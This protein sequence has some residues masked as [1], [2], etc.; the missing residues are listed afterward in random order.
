[1]SMSSNDTMRRAKLRLRRYAC[2]ALAGASILVSA[3]GA[4][5]T[6]QAQ[7]HDDLLNRA[8]LSQLSGDW[9]GDKSEQ[10]V[11]RL[12]NVEDWGSY[13]DDESDLLDRFDTDNFDTKNAS[14]SDEE[15]PESEESSSDERKK[16]QDPGAA[17]QPFRVVPGHYWWQPLL[18]RQQ[19]S[20]HNR[21]Q[22]D[23]NSLLVG[24]LANSARIQVIGEDPLISETEI[25]TADAAFDWYSFLEARWDDLDEPVGSTLT[26]GGPSRFRD[27][28][29]NVTGGVR[30]RN[31]LGGELEISQRLGHQNSNSVFFVPNNQGTSRLTFS[32]TQPLLRGA[33]RV[34]NTSMTVLAKLNTNIASDDFHR[35]L[36][37]HLLDVTQAY[38][39]LYFERGKLLQQ[40]K[41]LEN[42]VAILSEL[43]SRKT[44]DALQSQVVRA[45]AAVENRRAQ[46]VRARL[47]IRIAE[48]R[49]RALINDP[50]LGDTD[51]EL[52]PIEDLSESPFHVELRNAISQAMANRPEVN[53]AMTQIKAASVRMNL[54]KN[55]TLPLL[56]V[57]LDSYLAGLEGN[58]RV[59]GAFNDQFTEGVPSYGVGLQ[60]E[61]PIWNRAAQSRLQK[62]RLEL[63]RM[64]HQFRQTMETL[65]LEVEVSVH[66]LNAAFESL[67]AKRRA[68]E[69][70]HEEVSYLKD[71]WELLP[72]DNGSASLLLEDL[73]DAQDRLTDSEESLLQS[74]LEYSLAQV[75][76]KKSI[77]ALLSHNNIQMTRSCDCNLPRQSAVQVAP[78]AA[79]NGEVMSFGPTQFG[80]T[81]VVPNSVGPMM[82]T[83]PYRVDSPSVESPGFQTPSIEP[84]NSSS[85]GFQ[86]PAKEIGEPRGLDSA[87]DSP[88]SNPVP[89]ESPSGSARFTNPPAANGSSD[90]SKPEPNRFEEPMPLASK[91]RFGQPAKSDRHKSQ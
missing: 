49:L 82:E 35:Q 56:N 15:D 34:Y 58:S 39:N 85:E 27:H 19:R 70:A 18:K 88:F 78:P 29:V 87:S 60:Y 79:V 68:M 54:S 46:L 36:Q 71:R 47:A 64:Q 26:T 42:G 67:S 14:L 59:F 20:T 7:N 66:E 28:N 55:E 4:G 41:L 83:I 86:A 77:G 33:G 57:V 11:R 8:P 52:I 9:D 76:Y 89:F 91:I 5:T 12:S 25:T 73:L 10:R 37:E 2:S 48:A 16:S 43:E 65:K 40:E 81:Q 45:R 69:A 84:P 13:A 3:W 6:A 72:V 38:W 61:R 75:T 51:T 22:V 63:R 53:A 80:P 44:L 90:A 21:M 30:R 32:Y 74:T 31:S 23:L 62:R 50:A 17:T 24:A 1:M